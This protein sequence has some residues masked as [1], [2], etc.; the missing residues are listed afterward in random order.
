[1]LYVCDQRTF[2]WS[3]LDLSI[4]LFKK[5][6]EKKL[7]GN[8]TFDKVCKKCALSLPIHIWGICDHEQLDTP[9]K[10]IGSSI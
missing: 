2:N 1:M 6:M 9:K 8:I 10:N 4:S 5:K 7:V 3:P